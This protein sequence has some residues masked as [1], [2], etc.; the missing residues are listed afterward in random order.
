MKLHFLY[1]QIPEMITSGMSYL[2]IKKCCFLGKANTTGH[3][4]KHDL[5]EPCFLWNAFPELSLDMTC[6]ATLHRCILYTS[7]IWIWNFGIW[8][9]FGIFLHDF[10][11]TGATEIYLLE[12]V[13]GEAGKQQ[14]S[15]LT[16]HDETG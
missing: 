6:E 9:E 2:S 15:H 3:S 8:T 5:H 4:I 13:F 12:S 14:S 16:N 7:K 10:A 1:I 11:T